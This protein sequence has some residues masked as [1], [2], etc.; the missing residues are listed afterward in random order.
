MN[1]VILIGN[2]FDLAHGLKTRYEDFINWY[3]TKRV[4]EFR[5]QN[6][7]L[8]DGL[9]H[10]KINY[11]NENNYVLSKS[12]TSPLFQE[13]CQ[14]IETKK[15]VDIEE[16]FYKH[17][18]EKAPE[19]V[20][21]ELNII[22][23]NLI[24]Y[25][26]EIQRSI[27]KNLMI[28]NIKEKIAEPIKEDDIAVNSMN[29][30][31]DWKDERLFDY[32]PDRIMVL[33]FNYTSIANMYIPKEDKFSI[34]H[35]HGQLNNPQ[36]VIFGYGDEL[37]ENYK[38][39]LN[40]KDN[41]YLRNIKSIRYLESSNYRQLLSFIEADSYQ[42]YIMGHSCGTSDRTLLNTLFEH[43]N[44]VSIK[45]FYYKNADGTDNYMEITQNISRNFTNMKL[46][47]DRVVN[48]TRCEP[49]PQLKK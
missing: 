46:M 21:K 37:D 14:L 33:N 4:K 28:P 40:T 3:W 6:G 24:E 49:M 11:N 23:C 5:Y 12:F 20:N 9:C 29:T 16:I 36:S 25:L 1:R 8:N 2:G 30:Y 27:T 10:C 7:Q 44:C 41:E 15:W 45:P 35:I 47:R 42:V 22:K 32:T 48:K 17:L 31:N 38:N 43:K 39:I 18:T 26:K 34:I 19:K 13:I